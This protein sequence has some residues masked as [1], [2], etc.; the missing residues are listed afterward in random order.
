MRVMV[1]GILAILVGEWEQCL[2]AS[3]AIEARDRLLSREPNWERGVSGPLCGIYSM[4]TA[5]TLCGFEGSPADYFTTA[6]VGRS[7]SSPEQVTAM[8]E[9]AGA[10]ASV[11]SGMSGFDLRW[12]DAPF[13]AN[14]RSNPHSPAYDHWVV[15]ARRGGELLV[16]D[17]GRPPVR[18]READF[19]AIW[20]GVGVVVGS[21]GATVLPAVWLG[22]IAL[23]QLGVL[24]ALV[25]RRFIP[26]PGGRSRSRIRQATVVLAAAGVLTAVGMAVLGDL[27]NF[28]SGVRLAAAPYAEG[29]DDIASLEDLHA[30]VQ[31]QSVLVIDARSRLDY[32]AGSIPGAVNIPIHASLWEMKDYMEGISRD[33]PI[34]VFCQSEAC[35]WDEA[36]AAN[37]SA[38]GFGR[39]MVS[40]KGWAEYVQAYRS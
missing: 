5:L 31:D 23:L 16:Y 38:L 13:L 39:V 4:C 8:A 6:Y 32:L 20:S 22:R 26:A 40:N 9:T 2:H 36:V 30:F 37:L 18:V 35:T 3:E 15:V 11:V 17:S 27:P 19:M 7:G 33:V 21:P 29:P 14:V 1:A 34:V 24:I 28:S 25:L 10:D 12:L